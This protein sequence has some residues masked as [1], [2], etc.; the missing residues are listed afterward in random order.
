MK[1][2]TR[3]ASC[4]PATWAFV[5]RMETLRITGRI[6]DMIIRGGEN[7]YPCGAGGVPL[8]FPRRERRASSRCSFQEIWRGSGCLY[9]PSRWCDGY[10]GRGE[11]LL[12]RKIARH[13]IPKYIFFVDTFPMTGSGKIQKFKLRP[14]AETI[15]R[16]RYHA[17]L[18]I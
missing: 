13:K 4:I 15:A 14:R 17:G 1:R 16:A 18:T 6:K 9:H 12:P 5:M 2:S 10:G 11:R 3:M 8:S 7:I